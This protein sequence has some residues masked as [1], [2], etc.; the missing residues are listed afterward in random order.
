MFICCTKRCNIP[1]A[2]KSF[3]VFVLAIAN[4]NIDDS[5]DL[6]AGLMFASV[7]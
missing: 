7:K 2:V 3:K 5:E 6:N 4:R 1:S